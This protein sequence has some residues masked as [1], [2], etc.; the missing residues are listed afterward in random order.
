MLVALGLVIGK[1][2]YDRNTGFISYQEFFYSYLNHS[3]VESITLF[4]P[5]EKSK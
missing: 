3:L 2:Q 1:D 5:G 4:N